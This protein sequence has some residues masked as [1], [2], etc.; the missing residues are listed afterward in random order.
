MSLGIIGSAD[1]P[2][3]ILVTGSPMEFFIKALI[4][5]AVITAVVLIIRKIVK[6]GDK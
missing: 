4:I 1:G 3:S 2:T 5:V 6:N